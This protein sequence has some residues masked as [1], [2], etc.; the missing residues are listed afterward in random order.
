MW[1]N[2]DRLLQVLMFQLYKKI[3]N[4]HFSFLF[5]IFTKSS[6]DKTKQQEKSGYNFSPFSVPFS[7]SFSITKIFKDVVV[8]DQIIKEK[9]KQ[10]NLI[11]PSYSD[12]INGCLT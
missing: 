11:L 3:L 5:L 10:D 9:R 2:N 7:F 12:K 1:D 8:W 6:N 4:K